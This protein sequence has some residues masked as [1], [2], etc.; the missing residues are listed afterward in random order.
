MEYSSIN[1]ER[2]KI[3]NELHK[4]ARKNF[5]RRS[6]NVKGINDL[7]QIDLV[8]MQPYAKF[9]KNHKY[10]LTAIDVFSKKA[11]A[12][13]VINKTAKSVADAMESIFKEN[14]STPD[15]IQSDNGKEFYNKIFKNLMDKYNIKH[16]SSYS[17]LKASV[18]ERFNR[19]LKNK[20]WKV[21]S[22]RGTYKWIDIIK[23]LISTYNKTI[24][25]TIKM[26][27][28]EVNSNNEA[29]LLRTVH[30]KPSKYVKNKFNIGDVVRISKFKSVF[31]KGYTPNFSTE[32]F[33][34]ISCNRKFPV[35]YQ[36]EDMKQSPIAGQFYEM[37][38]QRTN[39]PDSY[40]V[41]KVL[42][43]KGDQVFVKWLGFPSSENS[44][45]KR[46]SLF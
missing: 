30:N 20:M 6:V 12:K 18:V 19:T 28:N 15:H 34:I 46:S 1:N 33:R 9:N 21:F 27:P 25:R 42:R 26:A 7:M 22:L 3:I 32:L 36:L 40:L 5:P 4:Q 17:S 39:Y 8:E 23:N 35:T 38:L 31:D 11:F 13:P 43:S 41:E 10:L 44:W 14:G 45:I 29:L 2:K 16:Y 24:H 37:E